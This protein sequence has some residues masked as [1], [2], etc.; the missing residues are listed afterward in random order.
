MVVQVQAC[1]EGPRVVERDKVDYHYGL[2]LEGTA[3]EVVIVLDIRWTVGDVENNKHSVRQARL[4]QVLILGCSCSE[5][6]EEV[7]AA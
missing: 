1:H 3:A 6:A 7:D 5:I 2:D 4:E